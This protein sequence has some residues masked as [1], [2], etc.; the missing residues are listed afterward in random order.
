MSIYAACLLTPVAVM[1]YVATGG[2][3]ATFLSSYIHTTIIFIV[4]V[5][6]ATRV[7]F[8]DDGPLGSLSLVYDRWAALTF[9]QTCAEALVVHVHVHVQCMC[10][11]NC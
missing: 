4:L 9:P 6:M 8:S 7:Y 3:T 10:F 2:L 5:L 11:K 1:L